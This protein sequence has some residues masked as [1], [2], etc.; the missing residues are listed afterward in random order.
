MAI[1]F[2]FQVAYQDCKGDVQKNRK[3]DFD[4][5]GAFVKPQDQWP[6]SRLLP[7]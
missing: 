3:Q 7:G 2:L 1:A 6:S 4:M 5:Y